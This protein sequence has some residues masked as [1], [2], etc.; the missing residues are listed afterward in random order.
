MK[1]RLDNHIQL[2]HKLGGE[3]DARTS[4]FGGESSK[5]LKM[6][7]ISSIKR[8][9]IES[10][11]MDSSGHQFQDINADNGFAERDESSELTLPANISFNQDNIKIESFDMVFGYR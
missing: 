3:E 1:F 10:V 9:N 11:T 2:K 7:L 8:E 5:N 4:M 6:P